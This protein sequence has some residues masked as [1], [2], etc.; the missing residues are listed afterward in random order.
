M[1]DTVTSAVT[2]SIYFCFKP[3]L[4]AFS[5]SQSTKGNRVL[6]HF[7]ILLLFLSFVCIN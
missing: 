3:A 2:I 5:M 1:K 4:G 6:P 7:T